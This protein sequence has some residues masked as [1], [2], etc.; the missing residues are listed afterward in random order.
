MGDEF[1]YTLV[2]KQRI[3][4][5][6]DIQQIIRT[7]KPLAELMRDKGSFKYEA[8]DAKT[9]EY[10]D[11]HNPQSVPEWMR[12]F[13]SEHEKNIKPR[14]ERIIKR[15]RRDDLEKILDSFFNNCRRIEREARNFFGLTD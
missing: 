5:D 2:L 10:A 3:Y 4:P 13:M 12:E 9:L 1:H 11:S 8:I 7:Q 14:Y 6:G 15:L